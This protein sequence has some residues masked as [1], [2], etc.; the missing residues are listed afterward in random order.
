MQKRGQLTL[1]II[2]GLVIVLGTG[3][4]IYLNTDT[5]AFV[6]QLPKSQEVADS[7]GCRGSSTNSSF[8]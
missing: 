4:I 1:F 2:I 8:C 5:D 6:A 3:V 7:R